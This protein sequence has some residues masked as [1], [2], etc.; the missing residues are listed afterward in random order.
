MNNPL[1]N[2]VVFDGNQGGNAQTSSTIYGHN[3]QVVPK[4]P[5][6]NS[7][8]DPMPLYCQDVGSTYLKPPMKAP[9]VSSHE[10]LRLDALLQ[11]TATATAADPVVRKGSY[12]SNRR[13][14]ATSQNYD[15][16]EL[17]EASGAEGAVEAA[18]SSEQVSDKSKRKRIRP[19]KPSKERQQYKCG[20][21][22]EAKVRGAH[23]CLLKKLNYFGEEENKPKQKR[24]RRSSKKNIDSNPKP[25]TAAVA[26][27][28]TRNS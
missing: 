22:G 20:K 18:N 26:I 13:T 12:R 17:K 4:M 25:A 10:N 6:E 7:S 2:T 5:A 11:A 3:I 23:E 24:R 16:I 19:P 21:C 15:D 1:R 8:A 28:K 9:S 27:G 14:S